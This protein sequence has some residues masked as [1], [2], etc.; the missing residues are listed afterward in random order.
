M[1]INENISVKRI[2]DVFKNQKILIMLILVIFTLVGYLYSYKYVVPKYQSSSTLLL[3]P[4]SVS[5]TV[6]NSDLTLNSELITTYS[7]I[8]KNPKVLKQ[9]ISNLKLNL[10]EQQLL[11]KIEV[12]TVKNTYIIKIATKDASPTQAMNITKEL[13]NVFLNEIQEIY[14]LNNIGIV[15]EAKLPETPY[16][17]NHT[18]DM[19]MFFG[20]GIVI[21]IVSVML[22]YFLNNKI[23]KEEEIEKYLQIKTLGSVPINENK[24]AELIDKSDLKSYAAECINAIRTNILYMNST[25]DAKSILITS[26]TPGEGKSWISANIATS[27]ADINKKVLLIDADLRKG[28]SY[29]IFNVLNS[30]GLSD[31]LYSM[32][33]N[34]KDNLELAKKYIKETSIPNLHILTNG[35]IPQNPSELLAS[36]NMK[37]LVKLL[38]NTYDIVIVDAP[39][40]KIVTDSTILSTIVDSTV[41]VINSTKTSINDLRD[42][43]KSIEL[44]GGDI[45]G[46]IVN[47]VKMTEHKYSNHYYYGNSK[48]NENNNY[49]FEEKSTIS[50]EDL[51]N[52]TIINLEN[53]ATY[54][55]S[56]NENIEQEIHIIDE[57]NLVN[58]QLE[59]IN[60]NYNK[61]NNKIDSISN[62]SVY[63]KEIK[64]II[65]EEIS[66]ID[67]SKNFENVYNELDNIKAEVD[68]KI[69]EL[70]QNN[71]KMLN[72]I[73][74]RT[75]EILISNSATQNMQNT[76]DNKMQEL[77]KTN[78]YTIENMKNSVDN[79][80]N[81]LSQKIETKENNYNQNI[82][83]ILLNVNS[84]IENMSKNLINST[85]N[86]LQNIQE[87]ITENINNSLNIEEKISSVIDE[88][89]DKIQK[90][91][92]SLSKNDY[93]NRINQI[94]KLV[95]DLK[96]SYVELYNMVKSS[97]VEN[98]KSSPYYAKNIVDFKT[99][100]V[101][102]PSKP[103]TLYNIDEDIIPYDELEKT[104]ICTILVD[105]GKVRPFTPNV[106]ENIM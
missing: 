52:Q 33:E 76:I 68:N 70:S 62:K 63:D 34:M 46:A 14:N 59:I 96:N 84:N 73:T 1:N 35:T 101:N 30:N 15:D 72:N 67:N 6:T 75:E 18:K 42:V 12:S 24:Q 9:V 51:V 93:N 71:S 89:L 50:V 97:D 98:R 85:N 81:E 21:S 8:A 82:N 45:I 37:E 61:L 28:R 102:K 4:N 56:E 10:T 22:I 2:L 25:K 87:N 69:N 104:A 19:I 95:V 80:I 57:N 58:S 94:N 39:P 54:N 106:Y 60:A 17:I 65:K 99:L 88:K 38:K 20:M 16:N 36:D 5:E 91:T 53:E 83:S 79:R 11:S 7:N 40:S 105:S 55:I 43:K 66:N 13:A 44:V 90:E 64:H 77:I 78:N 32:N 86:K 23:E 74:N 27:F 3:I 48:Q 49:K 31:Y 26:C 100:K 29:K 103:K 92:M 41:L 47:K